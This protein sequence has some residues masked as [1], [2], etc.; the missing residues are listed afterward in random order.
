M[1]P[2]EPQ[3]IAGRVA[4]AVAAAGDAPWLVGYDANGIQELITAS[5]RPIS[6]R[7]A[8]EA[9]LRFDEEVSRG[10][11]SIF[12]GG[13]R[14]VVLAR[15]N[16]DA[17]RLARA[18]VDQYR[19]I[20]HGGVVATSA[21]PLRR[22][23][24]AE[25]QSIRWLRR[26]L[27]IAKDEA[28]PPGGQLPGDKESE[29]AYCRTY[30]GVHEHRRE[31]EIDR[32]CARCD[33]MV[34]RGRDAN[35]ERGERLGEMSR[36]IAD[37]ATGGWIAVISADGNNLGALFE[38]LGTLAE[39][40][41]VSELVA[42]SFAS[43]QKRGLDKIPEQERLPLL[44]GGDDVRAF[45]PPWAVLSYVETLV[46]GVE[47]TAAGHARAAQGLISPT[48][49][50]RLSHLGVGVGAVIASVY[51]PAWRLVEYAHQLED[52]AKTACRE[53]GWRS[54][55]DFA[56]VTNEDAMSAKHTPTHAADART[57]TPTLAPRARDVFRPLRPRTPQWADA[58]RKARALAGVPSAQLALLATA[59]VDERR[60]GD[61]VGGADAEFGNLLRYQVARSAEWQ[62]W[63][64]ECGADPRDRAKVLE[65][66]PTRGALELVRLLGFARTSP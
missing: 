21:V 57:A 4:R 41:V 2:T 3:Q 25:A 33:A 19:A 63:Y 7:G 39:L 65:H 18:F 60:G 58:L 12:A 8:S 11:L 24:D 45:L 28:L 42:A 6:M 38:S 10:E 35:R 56:V 53:H 54:G 31:Q 51:Y 14:G 29:C 66:R 64:R 15:S 37:I 48:V 50:D 16:D 32:V 52:S 49:A 46:E 36:S 9:I 40:A 59:P 43:A 20:T 30:R 44:T 55:F 61:E 47:S 13:G 26:R 5:G 17:I 23:G 1:K 34:R 22:G 62:A 27:E